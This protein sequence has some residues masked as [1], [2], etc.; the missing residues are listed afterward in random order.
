MKKGISTIILLVILI[1]AVLGL[2]SAITIYSGESYSFESEEFE[3]YTVI[4][5]SSNMEGMNISWENGNTTINFAYNYAPDNFTLVFFNQEEKI[6]TKYVSS[7][8]GS[9][10]IKYVNRTIEVPNYIDREV[11][12]EIEKEVEGE[13]ITIKEMPIW[14]NILYVLLIVI[15]SIAL[16]K[17]IRRNK[18]LKEFGENE[19]QSKTDK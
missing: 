3:Y 19:T 11:I 18:E 9:S 10:S 7:G 14:L 2:A 13:K 17:S 4:G 5:N 1:I 12:K 8:G 16:L 15:F 6:I